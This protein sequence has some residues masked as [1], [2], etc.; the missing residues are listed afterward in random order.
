LL[1]FAK[2]DAVAANADGH[3]PHTCHCCVAA[4]TM[5]VLTTATEAPELGRVTEDAHALLDCSSLFST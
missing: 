3:G 1:T 4:G 2:R 5:D